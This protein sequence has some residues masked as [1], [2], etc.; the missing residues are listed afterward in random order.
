MRGSLYRRGRAQHWSG[1]SARGSHDIATFRSARKLSRRS[2]LSPTCCPESSLAG[3]HERSCDSRVGIGGL[4][5]RREVRQEARDH[6]LLPVARQDRTRRS[7]PARS[8]DHRQFIARQVADYLTKVS[9][10]SQEPVRHD[11]LQGA[12]TD[13][14]AVVKLPQQLSTAQRPEIYSCHN[15]RV[16]DAIGKKT[17]PVSNFDSFWSGKIGGNS[18]ANPALDAIN[19]VIETHF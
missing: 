19:H 17:T 8:V 11:A 14:V 10:M 6:W 15:R 4:A 13:G 2:T 9:L 18:S 7:G 16:P 5:P 3:L 1:R 12:R